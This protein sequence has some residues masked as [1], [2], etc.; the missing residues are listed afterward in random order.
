MSDPLVIA[1]T[2]LCGGKGRSA[3][4]RRAEV[5]DQLGV[6]EQT[7]Y[8]IVNGVKLTSGRERTV[9]RALREKLDRH[10]P[11][12]LTPEDAEKAM[13]EPDPRD[14]VRQALSVIRRYLVESYGAASV[15]A[16]DALH[17]LAMSPDSE[18][19]FDNA[20]SALIPPRGEDS[21][22]TSVG[23]MVTSKQMHSH[24]AQTPPVVATS[25]DTNKEKEPWK[26]RFGQELGGGPLSGPSSTEGKTIGEPKPA[27]KRGKK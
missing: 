1:L 25:G 11:G 16:A 10:F 21:P 5:A 22:L 7:L 19:N 20:L 6:N 17:L 14:E 4:A 12:W 8:Q 18:R 24:P 13:P 23:G 15:R 26:Q 3:A 9:G 2:R 27:L